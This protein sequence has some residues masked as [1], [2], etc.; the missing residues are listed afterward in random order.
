MFDEKNY[1]GT[2]DKL[3]EVNKVINQAAKDDGQI[4]GESETATSTK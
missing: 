2:I 1:D 3:E 4:K